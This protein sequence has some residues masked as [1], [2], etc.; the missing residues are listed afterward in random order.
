[1]DGGVSL[2]TLIAGDQAL[3]G[4]DGREGLSIHQA[5]PSTWLNGKCW[6]D[7]VGPPGEGEELEWWQR[8]LREE[9]AREEQGNGDLD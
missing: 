3:R 5:Y 7:E 1:M 8:R 2:E 9:K 4:R 6:L